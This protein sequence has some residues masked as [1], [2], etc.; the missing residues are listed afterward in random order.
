MIREEVAAQGQLHKVLLSQPCEEGQPS[1]SKDTREAKERLVPN[2]T[3][4]FKVL[5]G[6]GSV[7]TFKCRSRYGLYFA[8]STSKMGFGGGF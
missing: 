1:R 8:W 5:Y 2:F 7:S 3:V 4:S 6:F